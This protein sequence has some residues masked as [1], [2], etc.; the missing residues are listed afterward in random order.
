M[1][2]RLFLLVGFVC[3]VLFS[4]SAQFNSTNGI[5][6]YF[7]DGVQPDS[8]MVKGLMVKKAKITNT[9]LRSAL[10]AI[11]VLEDSVKPAFPQFN[12]ADTLRVLPDGREIRQADMSRLYR[13]SPPK[14][15]DV[16]KIIEHLNSFPEV[17][18]AEPDGISTPDIA[19]NDTHYSLHQWNMNN[20]VNPGRDIHAEAAWDIYTGNPNNIIA[21]VDGGVVI[22][23]P[24]LNDKISGGDTGTGSGDW[25]SHGTHVAGIAAAES[26]NGQGVAGVDWNARIHPQRIDLGGD[27]ENY[28]AIVDAVDHSSNVFVLNNSYGL[29]N[30]DGTPGRYSTTVRQAVAYA[31]K[32]NR[33]FVAS[34]GNHQNTHPDVINYPAGYPNVIA[35]GSTNSNDV[36]AGSS[37]HGSYI[38]V[39]AP[40]VGIYS[41]ITGNTYDYLSGTS[42]ATPHVA[43]LASLLKGY[44]TDL[45]NDD[46]VNIIRLSA[47]KT[48]NMTENFDN[49]YGYGR[50]NAAR[51]LSY[52]TTPYKLEQLTAQ[53][54]T[55][56]STSAQY[57]AILIS[58]AA[59]PTGIYLV[60]RIEVQRTVDLP[61][62]VYNVTGVWGRGV[63][64][65][66]WSNSNPNFGEGFCEVVPGSLTNSNV[67]LRTYVYEIYNIIG[68]Y[69]GYYPKTPSN[70]TFAYSVLGL[71]VPSISGPSPVCSQAT[72]TINPPEGSTVTWSTSNSNLT[73]L[74]GQGTDLA[75][76]KKNGN[77]LCNV[78]ATIVTGGQSLAV[79]PL[80]VWC[81]TP[82]VKRIT[83][84]QHFPLGGSG[85]YIAEVENRGDL[86]YHW[87][88][89]PSVPISFSGNHAYITF[90]STNGDYTITLTVTNSCGSTK[91]YHYVATGEYEPF[92]I[93]P[94]PA[95]DVVT[96][97]LSD[98]TE[99]PGMLLNKETGETIIKSGN[100]GVYEIQLWSMST[101]L[102][103]FTTDQPVYQIPVS[104]LPAGIY[105]VRVIKDGHTH[106]KKLIKK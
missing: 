74:S 49:I 96:V 106:T 51:A 36:I 77:G 30:E 75:V 103:R 56:I 69:Y 84:V 32:H 102:K 89:S 99:R 93:Y 59:F 33:V 50:I 80:E 54:G 38:D 6:V 72:Y 52:L 16:E 42:M 98:E 18:Y 62:T 24:D 34:M 14:G 67:T 87:S 63:F 65:T 58:A 55:V 11:A 78:N 79:Q 48:P 82:V 61:S 90:P 104:G 85:T 86:V 60:K 17:L 26:N 35:V 9:P 57:Q 97:Q 4:T 12:R 91:G 92:R 46:V 40:G 19:P 44:N 66:G 20:P 68:Q 83:G 3:T 101:M 71:E 10:A 76:F 53:G 28:Q 13:I 27:A 5:L 88:V 29:R 64:T 1:K 21:I 22:S 25:V 73:L 105:F 43:G 31:Y 37:V 8:T 23:H 47:D 2:K 81:G 100:S 95:T 39:C 45:A 15:E 41:T 7:V 94:N 70:V